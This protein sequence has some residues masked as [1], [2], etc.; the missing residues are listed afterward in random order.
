MDSKR[1][2]AE[3]RQTQAPSA[4]AKSASLTVDLL[5]LD[6]H[7]SNRGREMKATSSSIAKKLD[8]HPPFS[9]TTRV[10]DSHKSLATQAVSSAKPSLSA[11]RGVD[12]VRPSLPY[13]VDSRRPSSTASRQEKLRLPSSLSA[14]KPSASTTQPFRGEVKDI[15]TINEK[16]QP[17]ACGARLQTTRL[18]E[19]RGDRKVRASELRAPKKQETPF[20]DSNNKKP[21]TVSFVDRQSSGEQKSTNIT[22]APDHRT[23]TYL[24]PTGDMTRTNFEGMVPKSQYEA[25]YGASQKGIPAKTQSTFRSMAPSSA[26]SILHNPEDEAMAAR[27]TQ[28]QSLAPS[29]RVKQDEWAQM[30]LKRMG[31]CPEGFAWSRIADAYQC[32]GGHHVCSDELLQEGKGGVYV[33]LERGRAES[34]TKY[35]PYYAEP[36]EPGI[37]L[38]AGPLPRPDEAPPATGGL[39][40]LM[41]ANR[42][43]YVGLSGVP[44]SSHM[45]T[46][47]LV[48]QLQSAAQSRQTYDQ[49]SPA[50]HTQPPRSQFGSGFRTHRGSG[51]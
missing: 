10:V 22:P 14:S 50:G 42:G 51:I 33:I 17:P 12:S 18:A 25:M 5:G 11:V 47:R 3:L 35:G 34:T 46:Q 9:S 43:G 37:F 40:A 6:D 41:G 1:E 16:P 36:S 19:L 15:S 8:A 7:K 27:Q 44:L 28:F 29:D 48:N 23:P 38:Y 45:Q 39:M 13:P 32:H 2:K 26:K 4:D 49:M 31:S 24:Q 20:S 21:P 30:M